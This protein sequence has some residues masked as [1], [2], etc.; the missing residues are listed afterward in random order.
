MVRAAKR[1]CGFKGRG[2]CGVRGAQHA[3]GH[4]SA[5]ARCPCTPCAAT[6][7]WHHTV[8][9][10][11]ARGASCCVNCAAP[12]LLSSA[13]DGQRAPPAPAMAAIVA[14]AVEHALSAL[15][16]TPVRPGCPLAVSMCCSLSEHSPESCPPLP[17]QPLWPPVGARRCRRLPPAAQ[18]RAP[19]APAAGALSPA[20]RPSE[21]S[22][23]WPW[24]PACAVA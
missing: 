22:S 13:A 16:A 3:R 5:A 18:M 21:S 7:A 2:C 6:A 24:L 11:A 1:Q 9:G 4:S 23:A 10:A 8:P 14:A 20:A 17:P 15:A 19:A 12:L